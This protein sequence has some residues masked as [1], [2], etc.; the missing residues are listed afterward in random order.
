MANADRLSALDAAFVDLD[1]AD[2]PLHVGVTMRLDGPP[3]TL[4][5]LRRHLD[6][7]MAR[8]PRLR[9]RILVAPG[10]D[11]LWADDPGFDV[12]RHVHELT[13]PAGGASPTA[14]LAELAG[15][16]LSTPL[17][18]GRPLWCMYLV[19]GLPG[20][21]WALVAQIHHVLLD[22]IA[23]VA[24][25]GLLLDVEPDP[26]GTPDEG[27]S[28]GTAPTGLA[29]ATGGATARLAAGAR[30]VLGASTDGLGPLRGAT[31]LARQA[32]SLAGELL[33]APAPTGLDGAGGRE[34][35]V[36][37]AT[38]ELATLR[39]AGRTHD[40]TVNDVL[41]AASS[42]ALG[43]ALA[44]RGE[45]AETIRALVPV[46]VRTEND[47]PLGNRISFLHCD[48][49]LTATD[50]VR[51]LRRVRRQM[52]ERKAN[53]QARPLEALGRAADALP[54]AG[55]RRLTRSI[56][57]RLGFT[58]IVSNVPGPPLPLYLMGRRLRAAHPAV[59]I[60]R[61]HA[62]TI[63]ALSYDGTVCLGL[64]ADPRVV[65][66]VDQIAADLRDT[67]Q[68]LGSATRPAPTPWQARARARRSSVA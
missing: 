29:A 46:N 65:D 30:T 3:P 53:G 45:E 9:Q 42:I 50:P 16:L 51:A 24:L 14:T 31:G 56:A 48:L 39:E 25:A 37:L 66:D 26:G 27:W 35:T 64:Y 4:A 58:A 38:V 2:A 67:L 19:R 49:P 41:L 54:A 63:G 68:L 1:H 52:G 6:G 62:V 5:G 21:E 17:P 34:R 10:G 13:A 28:P 60:L 36:A 18:A 57:G 23:G 61:G 15:V 59:P 8:A 11:A 40:A 43:R 32:R 20:D 33:R 12:A 44:R 22:G 55:R 7:R 47:G